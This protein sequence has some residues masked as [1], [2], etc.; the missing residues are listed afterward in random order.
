MAK[1]ERHEGT[2]I[3]LGAFLEETKG[4][5]VYNQDQDG[6]PRDILPGMIAE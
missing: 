2:V 4:A 3:E 6:S 5:L 1:H